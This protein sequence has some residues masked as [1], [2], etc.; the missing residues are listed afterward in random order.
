MFLKIPEDQLRSSVEGGEQVGLAS[1]YK[2]Q[3]LQIMRERTYECEICGKTFYCHV[4]AFSCSPLCRKKA[5]IKRIYRLR[6]ENPEKY[7]AQAREYNK[8]SREKAALQQAEIDR[9]ALIT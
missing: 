3:I 2:S 9:I 7:R 5:N 6:K 4:E 1:Y 8:R